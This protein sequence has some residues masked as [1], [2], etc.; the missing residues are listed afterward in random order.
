ML[1][2]TLST[3]SFGGDLVKRSTADEDLDGNVEYINAKDKKS[4]NKWREFDFSAL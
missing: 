1:Y 3:N 4:L 2:P